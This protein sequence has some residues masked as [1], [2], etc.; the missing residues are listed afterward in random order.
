MVDKEK[1]KVKKAKTGIDGSAVGATGETSPKKSPAKVR[2][3][4]MSSSQATKR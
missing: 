1:Q 3:E 2:I 4:R